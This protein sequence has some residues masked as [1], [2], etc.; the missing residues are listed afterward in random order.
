MSEG[1]EYAFIQVGQ[2]LPSVLVRC[3]IGAMTAGCCESPIEIVFG[4]AFLFLHQEV[5]LCSRGVQRDIARVALIPQYVW[6]RYRIDWAICAAGEATPRVFVEC[7]GAAFHSTDEQLARDKRKDAD[8]KTAG[9]EM[10]RFSGRDITKNYDAC[11]KIAMAH[12][13]ERAA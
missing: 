10:L 1:A 12:V 9:I 4:T 8:A 6:R 5:Q 2:A 11:A 13:L 7:D 3:A